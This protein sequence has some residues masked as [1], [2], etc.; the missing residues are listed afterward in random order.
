MITQEMV[1]FVKKQFADGVPEATIVSQL[2]SQGWRQADVDEAI[3]KSRNASSQVPLPPAPTAPHLAEK[4]DSLV[5]PLIG[6][7][8]GITTSL[9]W[10]FIPILPFLTF[11]GVA[12]GLLGFILG[13][14]SLVK[15]THLKLGIATMIIS[16]LSVAWLL[17]LL[18]YKDAFMAGYYEE[19]DKRAN[20]EQ[21]GYKKSSI[22]PTT[23]SPEQKQ[24]T[25]SD[26]DIDSV[27]LVF[28]LP[29]LLGKSLEEVQEMIGEEGI[30]G[31]NDVYI[32]FRR[33][34]YTINSYYD[35]YDGNKYRFSG[36]FVSQ[37]ERIISK[38]EI[39]KALNVSESNSEYIV[40][41]A[42]KGGDPKDFILGVDVYPKGS[43][44][45]SLQ[46]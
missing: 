25:K 5:L 38:E 19:L 22:T 6:L 40:K 39:F 43:T 13:I 27:K 29:S 37:G 1:E 24:P 16:F 18:A 33:G 4:S 15:T 30:V 35:Q 11:V 34:D 7:I 3:S 44:D 28:D 42:Y 17:F 41:I 2:L 23:T 46:D 14:I 31:E 21:A 20:K 8:I 9:L 26:V 45:F 32:A 36:V 10:F 12:L